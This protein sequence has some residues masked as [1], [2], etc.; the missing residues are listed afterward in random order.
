MPAPAK[1]EPAPAAVVPAPA[2]PAQAPPVGLEGFQITV[3]TEVEELSFV[4]LANDIVDAAEKAVQGV[5]RR[6]VEG[7]L[8]C[9]RYLA[10]ALGA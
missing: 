2:P 10:R 1:A 3:R 9:V 7:R 5:A 6:G 8:L 4:V